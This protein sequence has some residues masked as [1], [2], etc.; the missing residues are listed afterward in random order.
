MVTQKNILNYVILSLFEKKMK[1]YN[2]RLKPC[3]NNGSISF[4]LWS[5]NYKR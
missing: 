5:Y 2:N 4:C 1:K 3:S